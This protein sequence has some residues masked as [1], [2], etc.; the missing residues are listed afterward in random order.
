[1]LKM[2]DIKNHYTTDLNKNVPQWIKRLEHDDEIMIFFPRE[3]VLAHSIVLDNYIS[4]SK[5]YM[6]ILTVIYTT[7]G[8]TKLE[9]LLYDNYACGDENSWQAFQIM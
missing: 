7:N 9:E 6:S 4:E 2:S 5:D 3:R 8:T 1:M